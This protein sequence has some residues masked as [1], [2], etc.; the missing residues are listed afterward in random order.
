MILKLIGDLSR[1][2]NQVLSARGG[3]SVA[4]VS[5]YR[6]RGQIDPKLV[7]RMSDSNKRQCHPLPS[8]VGRH[9]KLKSENRL[10]SVVYESLEQHAGVLMASNL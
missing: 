5:T 10:G 4:A 2:P 7:L 9:T 3:G 6:A 1:S 8:H